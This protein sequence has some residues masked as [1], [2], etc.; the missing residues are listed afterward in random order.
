MNEREFLCCLGLLELNRKI[1]Q[2]Q[3]NTK[4]AG[5][6]KKLLEI[7]VILFKYPSSSIKNILSIITR[8]PL[9]KIQIWIQ[10]RRT[11]NKKIE[12]DFFLMAWINKWKYM[13]SDEEK[14]YRRI[15]YK[16]LSII[17]YFVIRNFSNL[18]LNIKYF[19]SIV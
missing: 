8:I 9:K 2:R 11:N 7:I 13:L 19:M 1:N 3:K 17:C 16:N 6:K 12:V 4:I 10:N 14:I 15:N 5:W 18:D